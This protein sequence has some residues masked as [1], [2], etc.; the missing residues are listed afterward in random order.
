MEDEKMNYALA[1]LHD[2]AEQLGTN[3]KKSDFT[4]EQ[5]CFIKQTLGP[6]NRA[7][8]KAGLKE[9][10]KISSQQKSRMKRSRIKKKKKQLSHMKNSG[11]IKDEEIR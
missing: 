7:L 5:V 4:P 11:G 2:K 8:E 9:P 10:Q 1:L 6:W 3:P